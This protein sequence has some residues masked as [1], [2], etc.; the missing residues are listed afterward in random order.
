MKTLK[1]NNRRKSVNSPCTDFFLETFNIKC[2]YIIRTYRV[3][4]QRT[5]I[6]LYVYGI[7]YNIS[8]HGSISSLTL[9][10]IFRLLRRGVDKTLYS[11]EWIVRICRISVPRY[12]SDLIPST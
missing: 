8:I 1:N 3:Y 11:S 9:F 5:R 12:L 4:V 2:R 10:P 7:Q 6:Q